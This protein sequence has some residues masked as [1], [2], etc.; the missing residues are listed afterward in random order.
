ME[1]G[2]KQSRSTS[3]ILI[4]LVAVFALV[5]AACGSDDDDSGSTDND[6]NG[7]DTSAAA[8]ASGEYELVEGST[9]AM[10]T[11]LRTAI[12][13][14]EPIVVTLWRPH[15]A[16]AEFD[17]KDL[18]DPEGAMGEGEEIY[19]VANKDW[20]AEN[21]ELADV[22]REFTL[23]DDQLGSLEN[24]VFNEHDGDEAAGVAAWLADGDNQDMVDGWVPEDLDGSG[25]TVTIGLIPWDEAI[26]V[27]ALWQDILED[28]GFTVEVTD[29]DAGI[30]FQGLADGDIDIF[31]DTWLPV[32]HQDYWEEHGDD[33]E[34]LGKWYEGSALLT[35]AVPSYMEDVNSIADLK[36]R[37]DEFG[38]QIIG[39]EPGAGLMRVTKE[40][41]IP[42]Y[43]L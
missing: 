31:L 7:S 19:G 29:V 18:E 25:E 3:R 12:E 24:F 2:T 17:I 40:E 37:A 22:F 32:T 20:A 10:L 14:E 39:I 9:P 33:L 41:A 1:R 36:G 26:V 38:G 30:L 34:R 13:N 15:W 42:A 5:L 21:T 43:G 6:G 27:T 23:D 4:A 28:H 11:E 8:G 35:I 16:Y